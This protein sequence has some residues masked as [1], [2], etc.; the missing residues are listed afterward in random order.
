MDVETLREYCLS[1]PGATESFP[2]GEDALVFKTGGKMF[3]LIDLKNP[4]SFNAKCDPERAIALREEFDEITPGYHMSKVHWNT[5]DM[6]GRL[7]DLQ[8]RELIDHSYELVFR[9]LPKKVKDEL[10]QVS[11][12]LGDK[13]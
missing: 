11:D 5:V 6:Q 8:L 2:F 3:L 12:E 7:S 9:G 1:K 10:N 13:R 4:V